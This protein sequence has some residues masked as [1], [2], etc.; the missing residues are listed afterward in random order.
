MPHSVERIFNANQI[1]TKRPALFYLLISRPD[2]LFIGYFQE[3]KDNNVPYF[4]AFSDIKNNTLHIM[5]FT[6]SDT[7]SKF[8][9]FPENI[10]E[11]G[12]HDF[13]TSGLLALKLRLRDLNVIYYGID[14]KEKRLQITKFIYDTNLDLLI[15]NSADSKD[16]NLHLPF[17]QNMENELSGSLN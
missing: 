2:N 12:E 5:P 4:Y 11:A 9:A 3:S 14:S 15:I 10:V 7:A 1:A 8:Y 6:L 17:V 16:F 13:F